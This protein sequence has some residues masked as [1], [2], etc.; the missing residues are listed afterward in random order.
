MDIKGTLTFITR[1]FV[2]RPLLKFSP[3]L[4][5]LNFPFLLHHVPFIGRIAVH[6]A[7]GFA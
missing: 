4:S 5:P 2:K 3:P 6:R 7:G 1:C